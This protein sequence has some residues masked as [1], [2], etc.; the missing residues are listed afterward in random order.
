MRRQQWIVALVLA[1]FILAI[2][3]IASE[4]ALNWTLPDPL[5]NYVLTRLP[6]PV[7]MGFWL[8]MVAATLAAWGG[9]LGQ[10]K[11]ARELYVA[12]WIADLL[13]TAAYGATVMTGIGGAIDTLEHLV[14]GVLIGVLYFTSA[15]VQESPAAP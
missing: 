6:N 3:T 4:F 10:W 11:P 12:A 14:G 8:L 1:D 7:L 2:L 15:P 9:L 5:R 13:L